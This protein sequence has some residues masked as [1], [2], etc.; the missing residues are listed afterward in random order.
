MVK[1]NDQP[2]NTF[3]PHKEYIYTHWHPFIK[4]CYVDMHPYYCT[5]HILAH[6]N[7]DIWDRGPLVHQFLTVVC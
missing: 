5:V 7:F 4:H 6:F 1:K 2:N 3:R